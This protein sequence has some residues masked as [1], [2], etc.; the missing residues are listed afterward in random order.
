MP[1]DAYTRTTIFD[2][3]RYGF[4][5]ELVGR[6]STLVT[7]PPLDSRHMARILQEHVLP[8]FRE[9][10]YDD[11]IYLEVEDGAVA[12]VATRCAGLPIGARALV[13]MLDDCLHKQWSRAQRGDTLLLTAA[14]V[15][16]DSC[17]LLRETVAV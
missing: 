9:A 11:G 14:S 13:P 4:L 1:P 2:V 8:A 17:V 15:L 10:C 7:L 12:S 16:A 3:I 5:E 6:F